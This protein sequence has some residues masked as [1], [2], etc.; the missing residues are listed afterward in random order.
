MTRSMKRKART[1]LSLFLVMLILGQSFA[2]YAK[3]AEAKSKKTETTITITDMMN[4]KVT[5]PKNIKKFTGTHHFGGEVAYALGQ[6][7]KLIDQ[8][9]Y[10]SLQTALCKVD[11]SFAAK[12]VIIQGKSFN[13]EQ[14]VALKP[15][16]VF[17]YAT[18]D[19]SMIESLEAVGIKCVA[20]RGETLEE[21]YA[22][23][24]LIA[25]ILNC[26]EKGESY[27]AE[28]DKILKIV[29]SRVNKIPTNKRAR[30]LFAGPKSV[31]T[32]ASDDM[33]DASIIKLGGGIS[34][35]SSI[36]GYWTEVSPEQIAKWNPDYIIL[37]SSQDTYGTND[38]YGNSNFSTIKAIKNK[39]VYSMPSNIGWWD[40]PAPNCVL[41]VLWM[42]KTIYPDKFKNVNLT[43]IADSFYTKIYGYSFTKLGGKL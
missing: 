32:V 25:K 33:M 11:K 19:A 36:K 14:L 27:I 29:S 35:S 2:G 21:S 6:Q 26:E 10:G 13:L 31:Y 43:K 41:G 5:L 12:P 24:R 4:R 38:I 15:D 17:I 37:A 23:I 22:S 16:V 1:I 9:V 7:D 3:Q 42:A 28:C 18:S 8:A 20:V 40:F 34:V 30:V 39:H